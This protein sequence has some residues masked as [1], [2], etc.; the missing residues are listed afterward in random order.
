MKNRIKEGK[1]KRER[2]AVFILLLYILR[3]PIKQA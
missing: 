1:L 2:I 3:G